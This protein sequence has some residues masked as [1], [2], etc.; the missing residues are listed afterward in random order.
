MLLYQLNVFPKSI[1]ISF[2]PSSKLITCLLNAKIRITNLVLCDLFRVSLKIDIIIM[3]IRTY[4]SN[5]TK[6][7]IDVQHMD[8]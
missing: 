8:V 7:L 3:R 5:K 6:S 4:P 1:R 2:G